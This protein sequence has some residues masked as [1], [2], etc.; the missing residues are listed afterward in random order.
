MIRLN[1]KILALALMICLIALISPSS[2]F[3]KQD[4]EKMLMH[5]IRQHI[6]NNML[7]PAENVRIELLSN[8][9]KIE[10][11]N[12]KMTVRIES[13]S[14]EEYLGDTS[15]SVRIFVNNIF[16]KEVPVRVRIEVLREFVVSRNNISKD[17]ILSDNDVTVQKKW[18][19]S[20]PMNALASLDEALGKNIIVSVRPNTQI[21]RSMIKEI[22]PVK[23]G[24]M[25][26]VILD[27]GAMKM[28]MNGIAEE[29]GAADA[30]VK[31]RNLTSN[32]IIY[33]RVVGQAKVQVDF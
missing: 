32:K 20:I 6:D 18:V 26:Q 33:A 4:D 1:G 27:S 17:S 12:G 2:A 9:P 29:D 13:R 11:L 10:N 15:F 24:K 23:K 3:C 7:W 19:R 28:M 25:V 21:T 8:L 16:F 30:L 14:R 5:E 22:M 31:V